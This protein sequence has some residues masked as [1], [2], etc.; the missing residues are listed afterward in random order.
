MTLTAHTDGAVLDDGA[1]WG[2]LMP[3][4]PERHFAGMLDSRDPIIAE[5]WAVKM[6]VQQ[7]PR[8]SVLTVYTDSQSLPGLFARHAQP[9]ATWPRR[10][11]R[12]LTA[13]ILARAQRFGVEFTCA[14][15]SRDEPAQRVAHQLAAD[16]RVRGVG[17]TSWSAR[18]LGLQLELWHDTRRARRGWV[19]RLDGSPEAEAALQVALAELPPEPVTLVVSSAPEALVKAVQAAATGLGRALL[20]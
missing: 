5:L 10:D 11:L 13:K 2:V 6:A 12:D 18:L 4:L 16:G 3:G 15:A 8:G 1:G 7:A 17:A 19:V 9:D 14:W 20:T